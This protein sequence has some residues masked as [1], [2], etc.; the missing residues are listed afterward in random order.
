MLYRSPCTRSCVFVSFSRVILLHL[1]QR[2]GTDRRTLDM[3]RRPYSLGIP[4]TED[5]K[6][7]VHTEQHHTDKSDPSPDALSHHSLT[8]ATCCS[9][10]EISQ[11]NKQ[12][13]GKTEGSYFTCL[14]DSLLR[15]LVIH[16]GKPSLKPGQRQ[17]VRKCLLCQVQAALR[18][19]PRRRGDA[20]GSNSVSIP[21]TAWCVT[22]TVV[23]LRKG[24][25]LSLFVGVSEGPAHYPVTMKPI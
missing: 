19:L 4:S 21:S 7:L 13:D 6:H 1:R 5:H 24:K 11:Q 14:L 15:S 3:S 18:G 9:L 17:P 10:Y 2:L 8:P 25:C 16:H 12:I 20:Q 22:R 23:F